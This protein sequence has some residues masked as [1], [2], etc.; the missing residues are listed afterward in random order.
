MIYEEGE[1]DGLKMTIRKFKHSVE[2][3]SL[4]IPRNKNNP[5]MC[6]LQSM[7]KFFEISN[8]FDGPLLQLPNGTKA[9]YSF[10]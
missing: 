6:P 2:P 9:T 5:V 7:Q 1:V 10:F 4:F 8:H 3:V